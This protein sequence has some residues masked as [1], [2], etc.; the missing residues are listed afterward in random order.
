MGFLKVS[1]V[2]WLAAW[3]G[4]WCRI[5]V[6]LVAGL[7]AVAGMAGA[8]VAQPAL[9]RQLDH[10]V[11]DAFLTSGPAGEPSPVPVIVDIDER[12]LAACGQWP[13]PRY[14]LARLVER[15]ANAGAASVALDILLAEEDRSS[16]VRLREGMK[17]DFGLEVEFAHVP[18]ALE[19]NDVLLAQVLARTPSVVG[20]F[21]RF[22]GISSSGAA[23]LEGL[24]PVSPHV[25]PRDR[26]VPPV[27]LAEQIP[28]GCPSPLEQIMVA[29]GAL[30]PLPSFAQAA[31]VGAINVAPDDDG[32]IR[33]VPLLFRLDGA[34]YANLSLRALM[35]G[36][37]VDTLVLASGPDGLEEIRVGEI[38][39][40]VSPSGLMQVA[41]RG[42]RGVY[43]YFSAVDV[44]E[45]RVDVSAIEGRVVFVGTSAAGLQ[46]IRA[47][48]F[49]AVYPG[50][51]AHAAVVDAVLSERHIVVPPWTPG[52][53]TLAVLLA[54]SVA[55]LCFSLARP[56]V[57]LPVGLGLAGCAMAGSAS[58]FR[59]GLFL[60]PVHVTLT[61]SVVALV[62]LAA[63]FWRE[64]RQRRVLRRAFNRYVAP[65]VVTRIAERGV[66][67]FAGEERDVTVLF[68]DVRGFTSLSETLRPDQVVALLNRYF[69]P[70]TACIRGSGGTLD[71]FMG[72]AIMAFWN[73]PLDVADHPVR[74]VRAALRMRSILAGLQP[75]LRAEFGVNLTVGTGI[76]TGPVYVG[77]MGSE[78]LLDYT[79]IGD[80]V[81][82][83]SR[84]ES[85]SGRYGVDIVCS[86][87][88]A[89]SFPPDL[90]FRRLDTIRVKGKS[91]PVHIGTVLDVDETSDR[92][93]EL[94]Q[95]RKALA[96]YR[97]GA[98]REAGVLFGALAVE[99]A[100]GE[101]LYILYEERCRT[102]AEHPPENWDGV[103]TFD[104]K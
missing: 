67:V 33:S 44:L 73:A 41:F 55:A 48:P 51:E 56:V 74:A 85:L 104:S 39:L 25:P 86:S 2:T 101:R 61:V 72:D 94:E 97:R 37:D 70:M 7:L 16:P 58:L 75:A 30:W 22:D 13:W 80:T 71:K 43:P 89:R 81:N 6:A 63:R 57:S 42:P 49:D 84:L 1:F 96:L 45:D 79:C 103:W 32:I 28:A 93:R 46:D 17:R 90:T 23:P 78:E 62:V 88:T 10:K 64:E 66:D 34:V 29:R 54:G 27:G 69:T 59:S 20:A 14:Q 98:F 11:Y 50:M 3:A 24:E 77:N 100:A 40:P 36:M 9:L 26:K 82:L 21:M 95:S 68:S 52:A 53:Q 60:S 35:R 47:T 99:Y 31:A 18:P 83:A 15:L 76:H 87:E 19:D 92:G 4:L 38:S 8:Y 12:S 102:L 5:P 65:E 91:R